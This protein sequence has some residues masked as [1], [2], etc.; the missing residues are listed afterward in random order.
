[1]NKYWAYFKG[2]IK[3]VLT[4][5]GP[6]LVW[7][8]SSL[9]NTFIMLIVWQ[10][11]SGGTTFGG[12]TKSELISYYLVSM[13]IQWINSWFPFYW[14]SEA[15]QDGSIVHM[16][17]RPASLFWS[18]YFAEAGWRVISAP[19]GIIVALL[20]ALNFSQYLVFP[21][22]IATWILFML[23][24]GLSIFVICSFSICMA[25]LAFF[26]THITVIDAFHWSARYLLGGQGIPF[27]F[28]TGFIQILALFLPFRYMLSFPLEIYFKKL[29]PDQI[30]IGFGMSLFWVVGLSLVYKLM[31]S[32]GIRS[33]TAFGN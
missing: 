12:Y 3:N 23:S 21:T 31:L 22:D 20:L 17:V 28:L 15:I 19:L 13:G 18:I 32:K 11:T 5:R 4:Y 27:S 8:L 9:L 29:S 6:M 30:L 2:N 7:V 10:A 14:V 1:M 26:F 24:L 33:Y 16:L 25:L